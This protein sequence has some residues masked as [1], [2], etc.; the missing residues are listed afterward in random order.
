MTQT[1]KHMDVREIASLARVELR[2]DELEQF[3]EQLEKILVYIDQ[4][5][6]IDTDNAMPSAH[7]FEVIN[8]WREDIAGESFS[9]NEALLNAPEKEAGQISVPR[10]VDDL[11]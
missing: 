5:Q 2:E 1:K 8:V 11:S 4:L 7:A 6:S 10:V 9:Q 3:G